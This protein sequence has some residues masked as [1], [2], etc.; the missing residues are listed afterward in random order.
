MLVSYQ[1]LAP[2]LSLG[3]KLY[4]AHSS[5]IGSWIMQSYSAHFAFWADTHALCNHQC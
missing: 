5:V 2:K 3:Q 1:P 4:P